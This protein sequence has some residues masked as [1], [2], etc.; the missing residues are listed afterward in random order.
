MGK[1]NHKAMALEATT[2]EADVG[3]SIGQPNPGL[4]YFPL[5]G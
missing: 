2:A 1:E 3:S 5:A 4:K